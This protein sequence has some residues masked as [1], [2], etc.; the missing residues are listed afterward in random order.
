MNANWPDITSN[1]LPGQTAHDRPDLCCHMLKMNLE[2]IMAE[3]K[4]GKV[5]GL[6]WPIWELLSSKKEAI[7]TLIW[8]IRSK[9]EDLNI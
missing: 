5:F 9:A 3:L 7:H 2:E 4:N 6:T 8:Y 1:L